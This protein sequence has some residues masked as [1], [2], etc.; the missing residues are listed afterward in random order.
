V[1]DEAVIEDDCGTEGGILLDVIVINED[2]ILVVHA[3]AVVEGGEPFQGG[4]AVFMEGHVLGFAGRFPFGD[5]DIVGAGE[6]LGDRDQD[7]DGH[8][9]AFACIM[10]EFAKLEPVLSKLVVWVLGCHGVDVVEVSGAEFI[11]VAL[12]AEGKDGHHVEGLCNGSWTD[13]VELVVET[14]TE[15]EVVSIE[16]ELW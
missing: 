2:G 3:D 6:A 16:D 1:F 7:G 5:W 10:V 12:V 8:D 13:S 14:A 15:V 9:V 11:D 4:D